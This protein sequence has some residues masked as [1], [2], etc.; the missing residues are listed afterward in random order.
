M[1]SIL[2]CGS[3]KCSRN[4]PTTPAFPRAWAFA[5]RPRCQLTRVTAAAAR[6][7]RH[8]LFF[9]PSSRAQRALKLRVRPL[10]LRLCCFCGFSKR[11]FRSGAPLRSGR[12][13]TIPRSACLD[14]K[15][16]DVR[17]MLGRVQAET[18]AQIRGTI[19]KNAKL[20]LFQRANWL[21]FSDHCRMI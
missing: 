16:G 10:C 20:L 12:H 11:P 6:V 21:Q 1:N 3:P 9:S 4:S 8:R 14:R 18:H 13:C 5:G 17:P 15:S 2:L 7:V 19:Q